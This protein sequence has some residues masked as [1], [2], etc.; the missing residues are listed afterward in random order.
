MLFPDA[1]LAYATALKKKPDR[2][3]EARAIARKR[4]KKEVEYEPHVA[5]LYEDSSPSADLFEVRGTSEPSDAAETFERLAERV[6]GPLLDHLED[7]AT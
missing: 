6:M 5:R 2:Q 4:W 7:D 3:S 1:S